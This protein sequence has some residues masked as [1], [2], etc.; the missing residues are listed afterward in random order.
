MR[1]GRS[2]FC[3][4]RDL[5]LCPPWKTHSIVRT[6]P[7]WRGMRV[8][9]CGSAW[10]LL[11]PLTG[12]QTCLEPTAGL[13]PFMAFFPPSAHGASRV[14]ALPQ[15]RHLGDQAGAPVL[16][17]VRP[18]GSAAYR[19]PSVNCTEKKGRGLARSRRSLNRNVR[20]ETYRSMASLGNDPEPQSL[21][22][23]IPH[24]S[25][26]ILFLMTF[27]YEKWETYTKWR[28]QYNEP[29]CALHPALTVNF[30]LIMD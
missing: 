13:V 17:M 15:A 21:H 30:L 18:Q 10:V 8:S 5:V 23:C 16:R 26:S 1:V 2:Q 22:L 6:T 12:I 11:N 29:V 4:S 25:F 27:Y 19:F 9:V 28:E 24:M 14:S 20:P 7:V 3:L